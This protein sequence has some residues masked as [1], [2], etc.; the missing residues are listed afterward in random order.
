MVVV[1]VGGKSGWFE[2]VVRIEW[3]RDLQIWDGA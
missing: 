1:V 2:V 3:F